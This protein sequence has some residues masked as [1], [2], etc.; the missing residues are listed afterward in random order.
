M[1]PAYCDADPNYTYECD[2]DTHDGTD[3]NHFAVLRQ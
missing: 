1:R 2:S 3:A